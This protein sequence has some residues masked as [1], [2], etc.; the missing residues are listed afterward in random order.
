MFFSEVFHATCPL[1]R[2]IKCVNIVKAKR[3]LMQL[4]NP[5][6]LK[7]IWHKPI[8][9]HVSRDLWAGIFLKLWWWWGTRV[10]N[11]WW[12]YFLTHWLCK[13]ISQNR[14]IYVLNVFLF[15]MK[16]SVFLYWNPEIN[17]TFIKYTPDSKNFLIVLIS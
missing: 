11:N 6:S 4:F 14:F 9:F 15:L 17:T 8:F 1:E 13:N 2:Y 7:S 5:E 3:K 12:K 10:K 16:K